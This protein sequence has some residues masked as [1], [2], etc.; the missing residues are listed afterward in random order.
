MPE[1]S[2]YIPWERADAFIRKVF[3]TCGSSSE[4]AAIISSCVDSR[5]KSKILP[6]SG[7]DVCC[8]TTSVGCVIEIV[9]ISFFAAFMSSMVTLSPNAELS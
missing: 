6:N 9:F 3:E 8:G 5:N 7:I 1:K 4:E 2:V